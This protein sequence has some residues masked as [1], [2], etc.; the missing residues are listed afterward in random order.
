MCE[1]HSVHSRAQQERA[2]AGIRKRRMEPGTFEAVVA[3]LAPL[4]LTEVI[5]ST[6]GEPL[7]YAHFERLV[8]AVAARPGVRL[9]LTTNGS[10]FPGPS[11]HTLASWAALL[12]PVLSDVKISWNGATAKTQEAIM[13]GSKFDQQLANLRAWVAARD[14]LA[15]AG[16]NRASVTLQL[17]FMATNL[18][19]IPDVVRLALA[20]GVDRVKGHHLWAHFAPI[21]GDDLRASRE[22]VAAWNACAAECRRIAAAQPLASG[23]RIKLEHFEDLP[24]ARDAGAAARAPVPDDAECPF[25]GR[26]AWVNHRGDFAPCCAPDAER[27]ALGDF[28]SV[29]EPGGLMRIWNS[30]AYADLVATYKSK[31]LC[32]T[33]Q[34]RKRQA[35]PDV[36][37]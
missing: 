2:A 8:A 27:R 11:G 28:G 21:K 23:R 12:L 29:H 5:P 16:G 37:A 7:M 6:M 32:S 18:A 4:G 9:N 25:L 24:A 15:T 35:R 33:C 20:H 14:A 26:E 30:P 34:M 17:T 3:E 31:P 13:R 36:D 19:E 22:S 1:Q 10:F